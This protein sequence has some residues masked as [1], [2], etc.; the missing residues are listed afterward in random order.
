LAVTV[1]S[2]FSVTVQVTVLVV[3]HPVHET[4]VL[5]PEVAGA[6]RTSVEPAL[7]LT[8]KLVVP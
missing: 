1:V 5:L 4:K 6:V 7:L 3:V 8:L 2:A